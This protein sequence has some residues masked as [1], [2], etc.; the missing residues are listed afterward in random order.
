MYNLTY[1]N[2]HMQHATGWEEPTRLKRCFAT[3][4]SYYNDAIV[5]W[6]LG[7]SAVSNT[8]QEGKGTAHYKLT[9]QKHKG[10]PSL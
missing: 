9:Q 4:A 5:I 10:R 2:T 1:D 8:L 7:G 3:I 6:R